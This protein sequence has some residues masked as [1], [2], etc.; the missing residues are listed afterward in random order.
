MAQ[1]KEGEERQASPAPPAENE[2]RIKHPKTGEEMNV[3]RPKVG[4][5][6]EGEEFNATVRSKGSRTSFAARFK[7][8][9]GRAEPV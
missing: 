5:H 4:A 6:K 2:L 8:V 7:V 9:K 1:K 3:T